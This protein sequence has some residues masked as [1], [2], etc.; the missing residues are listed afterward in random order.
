MSA[1]CGNQD[2]NRE[3]NVGDTVDENNKE[4]VGGAIDDGV[5]DVT[6]A[7]DDGVD[8]ITD[9]L[10]GSQNPDTVNGATNSSAR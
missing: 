8:D 1:A 7:V 5:K 2:E 4:N 10:A 9:D 3:N 6:D